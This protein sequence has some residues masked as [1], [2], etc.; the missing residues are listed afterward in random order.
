MTTTLVGVP[1][2]KGV[3]AVELLVE[4]WVSLLDAE[5]VVDA[6]GVAN[7]VLAEDPES[8]KLGASEEALSMESS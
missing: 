2:P 5:V 6:R 7:D 1:V 8:A 4:R 3:V